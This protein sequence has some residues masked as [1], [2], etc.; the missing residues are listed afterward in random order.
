MSG[1]GQPLKVLSVCTDANGA[2]N[3]QF[4]LTKYYLPKPNLVAHILIIYVVL[5]QAAI[6]DVKIQYKVRKFLILR[7][8]L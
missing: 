6:Q 1:S 5:I 8:R 2:P 4:C 7:I 3:P